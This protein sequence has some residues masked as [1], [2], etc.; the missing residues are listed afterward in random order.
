MAFIRAEAS[1]HILPKSTRELYQQAAHRIYLQSSAGPGK[2]LKFAPSGYLINSS[3]APN[4]DAQ[5]GKDT[6]S[7]N[8]HHTSPSYHIYSLQ[9][10]MP[11]VSDFVLLSLSGNDLSL[12]C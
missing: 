10:F 12:A 2:M 11:S 5:K 3:R 1:P 8:K 4:P 6:H 9:I 7:C